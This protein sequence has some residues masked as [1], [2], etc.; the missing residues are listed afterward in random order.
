MRDRPLSVGIDDS[1]SFAIREVAACDDDEVDQRLDT[2][3]AQR[4]EL[5]DSRARFPY[6]ETVHADASEKKAEQQGGHPVLVA[7][8]ARIRSRR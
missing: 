5:E 6:I 8:L 3:A 7:S 2:A 4:D 1:L